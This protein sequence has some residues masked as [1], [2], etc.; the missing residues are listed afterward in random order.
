MTNNVISNI[1]KPSFKTIWV[2]VLYSLCFFGLGVAIKLGLTQLRSR[3]WCHSGVPIGGILGSP[4]CWAVA[5]CFG[6]SPLAW[7]RLRQNGHSMGHS[8][9]GLC[10]S[11]C[12]LIA[13]LLERRFGHS[14]HLLSKLGLWMRATWA[15]NAPLLLKTAGHSEHWWMPSGSARFFK[16]LCHQ[17]KR[18]KWVT[19]NT[20]TTFNEYVL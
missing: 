6:K 13:F 18:S 9:L 11:R 5:K 8:L 2:N 1:F 16:V 20:T 19:S 3:S 15:F 7:K 17:K 10:D 14:G 12:F 4:L